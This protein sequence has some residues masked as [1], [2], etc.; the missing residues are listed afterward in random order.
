MKWRE[1]KKGYSPIYSFPSEPSNPTDTTVGIPNKRNSTHNPLK[2]KELV[3]SPKK[4]YM[5]I[6]K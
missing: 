5:L 2:E 4:R 1:D 6:K 3:F